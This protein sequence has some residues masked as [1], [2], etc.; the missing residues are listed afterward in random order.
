VFTVLGLKYAALVFVAVVGVLQAA[1]AYNK[2]RGMLFFQRALYAYIFAGIAIIVPLGVFFSWNYMFPVN[3]IAGSQQAGLFFFTS[4]AAIIVTLIV[5]SLVNIKLKST[6]TTRL[7][8][9]DGLK[10]GTLFHNIK[11]RITGKR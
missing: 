10:E 2:L 4:G 6:G 11:G 1:A 8:G 7:S 5:S 3:E 9:L